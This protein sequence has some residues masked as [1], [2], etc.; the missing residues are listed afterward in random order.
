M[1]PIASHLARSLKVIGTD[2]DRSV[3]HHE[4]KDKDFHVQLIKMSLLR[5]WC[6]H[7]SSLGKIHSTEYHSSQFEVWFDM[8]EFWNSPGQRNSLVILPTRTFSAIHSLSLIPSRLCSPL[9]CILAAAVDRYWWNSLSAYSCWDRV[10]F[11]NERAW[12]QV[13][14]WVR[15]NVYT[16]TK[17]VVSEKFNS[18]LGAEVLALGWWQNYRTE[19]QRDLREYSSSWKCIDPRV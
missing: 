11:G 2:M 18:D 19:S 16:N 6:C 3:T 12:Q 4:R 17:W 10:S 15:R 14:E 1:D 7:C 13:S 8:D 9:S 5:S